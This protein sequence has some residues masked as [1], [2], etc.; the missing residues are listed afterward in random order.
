MFWVYAKCCS[1]RFS[2]CMFGRVRGTVQAS[3]ECQC[4]F[5]VPFSSGNLSFE[6]EDT[7]W[8]SGIQLIAGVLAVGSRLIA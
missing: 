8:S 4:V 7:E 3:S 1:N 6:A 5:Q 2:G